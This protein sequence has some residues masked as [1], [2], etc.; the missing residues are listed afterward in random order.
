M[1]GHHEEVQKQAPDKHTNEKALIKQAEQTASRVA[2][3][4]ST[5]H[6][7]THTMCY[8]SSP[9][10]ASLT[11]RRAK[12]TLRAAFP[13]NADVEQCVHLW[14]NPARTMSADLPILLHHMSLRCQSPFPIQVWPQCIYPQN[15][16]SSS[17]PDS[18]RTAGSGGLSTV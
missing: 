1:H 17:V 5:K 12:V 11:L 9:A 6:P 7:F 18:L 4:H 13:L 10:A 14:M 3:N 15:C 2:L 16:Y 8:F